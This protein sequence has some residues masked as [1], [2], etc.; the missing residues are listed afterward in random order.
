MNELGLDVINLD[1]YY[2][3][4]NNYLNGFFNAKG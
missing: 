2:F 1:S 4:T 3:F